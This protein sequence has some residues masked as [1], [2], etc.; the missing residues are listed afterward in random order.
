MF[1]CDFYIISEDRFIELNR[2]WT[3]NDH[4]FNPLSL[5]DISTLEDWE[6]K[7]RNGR[8]K[9]AEAIAVWSVMD[10]LKLQVA[11]ENNLNYD[12]IY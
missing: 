10:P 11:K 2:F 12:V 5:E 3:H 1:E 4:P 8:P 6:D 9:Y 7:V